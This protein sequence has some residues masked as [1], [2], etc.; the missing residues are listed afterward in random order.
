MVLIFPHLC[1]DKNLMEDSTLYSIIEVSL[2]A[3]QFEYWNNMWNIISKE[4]SVL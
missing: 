4:M 1:D 3:F 2:P